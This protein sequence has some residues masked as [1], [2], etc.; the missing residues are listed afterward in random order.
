MPL[1]FIGIG[2]NLGDREKNINNSLSLLS[3][4]TF[5]IMNK[6]AL[7][8]T[9]PEVFNDQPKYLN[10]AIA[11][12]TPFEPPA[13]LQFLHE[14]ESRLGRARPFKNCPRTIDLDILFYD[15]IVYNS[16][17]LIIPHPA[18]T[19]RAFVLVPLKEIAPDFSHPISKKSIKELVALVDTSGVKSWNPA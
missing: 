12:E 13:C 3:G 4:S 1:V 8:E 14:I 11:A 9:E 2:S 17:D 18:L 10:M 5:K 15:S 6:S 19:E 16:P 7:Y